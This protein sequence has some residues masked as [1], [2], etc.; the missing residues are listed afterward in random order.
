MKETLNDEFQ[1]F[2]DNNIKDLKEIIKIPNDNY[3]CT[4]CNLI[5]K[6]LNIDYSSGIIEFECKIHHIKKMFLKNYLLK[7]SKN[8]YIRILKVLY[9][10]SFYL[11]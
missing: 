2:M 5:P 11:L 4:E 7:M 10:K 1:I 9:I 8:I 3:T 6:I